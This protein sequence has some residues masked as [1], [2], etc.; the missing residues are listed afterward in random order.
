M[1]KLKQY[2][3]GEL[4]LIYGLST[5]TKPVTGLFTGAKFVELDTQNEFL[6][7]NATNRWYNQNP[8]EETI[9][10]LAGAIAVPTIAEK[11]DAGIDETGELTTFNLLEV[12]Y[13]KNL[14]VEVK[15]ATTTYLFTLTGCTY[16]EMTEGTWYELVNTEQTEAEVAAE[17]E[18]V[19]VLAD[20]AVVDITQVAL[21]DYV[22]KILKLETKEV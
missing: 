3:Q 21:P 15:I 4:Q 16:L 19:T 2:E 6:F 9:I 5:E 14:T 7:D 20:F 8:V 17:E 10:M 11:T 1:K 12:I 22:F 18:H 13:N